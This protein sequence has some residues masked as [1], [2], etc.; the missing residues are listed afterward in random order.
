MFDKNKNENVFLANF[1]K[2]KALN[3]IDKGFFHITEC[4]KNKNAILSCEAKKYF[5]PVLR[6]Y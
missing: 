5:F 3:Y 4:I 6:N 1:A 2:C